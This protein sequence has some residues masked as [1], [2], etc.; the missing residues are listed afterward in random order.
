MINIS[1]SYG[2]IPVYFI[3][4]NPDNYI[5]PDGKL[6]EPVSKRHSVVAK[7]LQDI[8]DNRV[9]LPVAL[10][11]VFYMYYDGWVDLASSEWN[12]ISYYTQSRD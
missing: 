6:P 4:W 8:C 2:G 10:L 12:V 9:R 3:R 11:S 7:F 5:S 1:Q